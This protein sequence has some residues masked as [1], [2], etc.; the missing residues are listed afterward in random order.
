MVDSYT[1]DWENNKL[2]VTFQDGTKKEYDESIK[3]QYIADFPERLSDI[4]AIGW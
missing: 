4:T 1:I 2:V 3:D